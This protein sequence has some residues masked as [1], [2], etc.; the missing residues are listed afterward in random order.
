[1]VIVGAGECGARAAFALREEGYFGRIVLIGSETHHPYERPPLSKP[2]IDEPDA[3][4]PKVIADKERMTAARIEFNSD[5]TVASVDGK[6]HSVTLLDGRTIGYGKLLLAT[7]ASPRRLPM[8]D[9]MSRCVYLRTHDDAVAIG[10]HLKPKAQVAVI[11]GGFIGLEMA[12]VA[13]S[14]GCA[15]TVIETQPR[16]LMRG[17]AAEL[18]AVV[19][20]AHEARGVR[21]ICGTSIASIEQARDRVAIELGD[22]DRLEVDICLV[23]IGA[24][25]NTELAVSAGLEIANGIAVDGRLQTSDPDIYAAGDCCSFPLALYGGRRVRLKSWR[26]AQDQG[27]LAARTMLGQDA[28]YQAVPWF[29]S[30]QYDLTLQIAGLADEGIETVRRDIGQDAFIL[31][32][33]A[34]DGRLVAGSG[35]GRGNAVAR[36]IRLTERLIAKRASPPRDRLAAPEAS[37][38]ALLAG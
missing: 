31:F 8:A 35:I 30:D 11:G 4:Y 29:W 26:N 13:R 36:D 12:A 10:A 27:T 22:G 38:K 2:R 23:G 18:A 24:H 32:H 28:T 17:V 20:E 14:L 37:L 25:P 1:M 7:G 33:L 34:A 5:S 6:A 21:L 9:G 19:H 3:P 16:I 15:V